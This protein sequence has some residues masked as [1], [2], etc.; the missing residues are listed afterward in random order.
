MDESIKQYLS[1]D[2]DDESAN[3]SDATFDLKEVTEELDRGSIIE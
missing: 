2:E 1:H 3:D